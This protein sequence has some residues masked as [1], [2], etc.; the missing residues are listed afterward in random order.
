M[1]TKLATCMI[2]AVLLL[3]A[4]C[5]SDDNKSSTDSGNGSSNT[6]EAASGSGSVAA[7]V[8]T[9]NSKL[10][11]ILTNDKGMTLYAFMGDKNGMPSCNDA[12][13]AVW[14]ALTT[15]GSSL[16]AGLDANVFKVVKRA[17]G[18]SQIVAGEWPLYTFTVDKA[19]GDTNGQGVSGFGSTWF[20]VK[21][22]GTLN[23][24]A[25]SST[26]TTAGSSSGGGN[27]NY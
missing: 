16:P 5:G 12:C 18:K 1:R 26:A 22:D 8:K 21:A 4:A 13:A 2:A 27:Y 3:G 11:E 10:G 17:D 14:P 7:L 20:T 9:A 24:D 23:K 6:T 15:S 19:A 25:G